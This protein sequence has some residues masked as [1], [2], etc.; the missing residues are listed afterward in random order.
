MP[1]VPK[2]QVLCVLPP[3]RARRYK[4]LAAHPAWRR[5][6]RRVCYFSC[7]PVFLLLL[8]TVAFAAAVYLVFHPRA[9]S[10]SIASISIRGLNNLT[11][12]SSSSVLSPQLNVAMRADNGANKKVDIDYRGGGE[13]TVSY[14]SEQLGTGQWSAFYQSPINM[15]VFTTVL[16]R[17]VHG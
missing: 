7:G 10:F 14:S 17:E 1:P 5:L 8:L 9:P 4:K 2:D 12:S 15:T 13:V 6:L 16:G 11:L 3:D